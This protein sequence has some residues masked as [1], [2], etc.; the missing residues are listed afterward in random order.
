MKEELL[1][2]FSA[3]KRPR[4]FV[5]NNNKLTQQDL[6]IL[7]GSVEVIA[8]WEAAIVYQ[9]KPGT[10]VKI[11]TH[12]WTGLGKEATFHKVLQF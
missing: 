10:T 12:G 8:V 9:A 1:E 4:T 3:Q 2:Y 5:I 6:K 11:I 7:H